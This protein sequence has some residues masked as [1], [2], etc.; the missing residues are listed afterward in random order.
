MASKGAFP[1]ETT[2][3][4]WHSN[5]GSARNPQIAADDFVRRGRMAAPHPLRLEQ[6]RLMTESAKIPTGGG[7]TKQFEV[8][9]LF[10]FVTREREAFASFARL[11]LRYDYF[12]MYLAARLIARPAFSRLNAY[13]DAATEQVCFLNGVSMG[14]AVNVPCKDGDEVLVMPVI[15]RAEL[16][17][18][19]ELAATVNDRIC[20]AKQGLITLEE[21]RNLGVTFNNTGA[22]GDM[23]PH[24]TVPSTRDDENRIRPTSF[25]FNLTLIQSGLDARR[26]FT[27]L[28]FRIDHRVCDG[29]LPMRMLAR[30]AQYFESQESPSALWKLIRDEAS[31]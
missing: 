19:L 31:F 25:L 15:E 3:T 2:E 6:S 14:I 8:T 17:S 22:L 21:C 18:F 28:A 16:L 24:S 23:A 10:A 27:R 11:P 4:E 9:D 13:W 30:I 29:A 7:M 1:P 12:F 5:G 20:R 26:R